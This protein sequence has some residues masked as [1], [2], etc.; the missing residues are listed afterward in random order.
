MT[1]SDLRDGRWLTRAQGI[2]GRKGPEY[3]RR[4]ARLR[5]SLLNGAL[6]GDTQ[7]MVNLVYLLWSLSSDR[8][9]RDA[10]IF[11]VEIA[12]ERGDPSALLTWGN[13]LLSRGRYKEGVAALR[14]S[15]RRGNED[16]L[17]RLGEAYLNGW[18]LGGRSVSRA[19]AW[20]E[21]A[22]F[23][24]NRQAAEKIAQIY[25]FLPPVDVV[26][27][28]RWYGVA[29]RQGSILAMFNLALALER[30]IGVRISRM[31]AR[32]W[33]QAAARRGD[34]DARNSLARIKRGRWLNP[35]EG[36]I[37]LSTSGS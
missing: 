23:A 30:G 36:A 7:A 27:G 3:R 13:V 9:D 33:Y 2:R 25:D 24:G 20:F 37:G 34:A 4:F 35:V 17:F 6:Q 16:A 12:A 21:R 31:R 11:W 32:R 10:A 15:A 28:V 8:R 5:A 14:R 19:K 22:H 29:A 18:C 26:S 1:A